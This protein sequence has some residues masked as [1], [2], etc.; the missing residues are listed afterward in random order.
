MAVSLSLIGG[1]GWQFF[2]NSGVPLTGG[3]VYTYA[4]GTTTPAATYTSASGLTAHT[5]PIVLDSAGR[6]PS[7]IWLDNSVSYKFVLKTSTDVLIATYDDVYGAASSADVSGI[8]ANFANTS[9]VSKGDA[10]VGFK[11]STPAGVYSTAVGRTVHDKLQEFVSPLDFGAS[12]EGTLNDSP[13]IQYAVD[14]G[15]GALD[16]TDKV[17]RLGA[18]IL[19]KNGT[20]RV[21][22]F[23][24]SR[25]RT[26]YVPNAVDI[27]QSPQNVN[28]LFFVQ[29][30]NAH[31]CLNNAYFANGGY[32]YTGSIIYCKEGGGADASGQALFSGLFSNL[33]ISPPST[34]G[35]FLI[36]AVQNC[37]F[38]TIT[39]ENMK[40]V[41]NLQG[42][43][44]G[45]VFF[46]NFSLYVCYDSFIYQGTDTY[47]A[48]YFTVNNI[49]A[50]SHLRGRL[51]DV[52]N[53]SNCRISNVMIAPDVS[54][55]GDTGLFKFKDCQNVVVENFQASTYTGSG[56]DV[57][58]AVGIEVD[59]T[60]AKF[61]SGYVYADVG[62]MISGTGAIDIEIENVDFSRCGIGI[63]FNGAA[64]GTIRTRNCKFNNINGTT[65]AMTVAN[66]VTWI[67]EGD[68]FINAGMGGAAGDRYFGGG[69]NGYFCL[70]N[71]RIGKQ[72]SSAAA[73][74]I[75]DQ[76]GS[77]TFKLVNPTFVG[78]PTF[79]VKTGAS[80]LI[81]EQL[82][83]SE[84]PTYGATVGLNTVI[85][86]EFYINVTN[87]TAFTIDNPLF[88]EP[89]MV[90]TVTIK[91]TSGGAV[92]T[93]TWNTKFKLSTWTSPATG[94][95]RSI[96]F[97]YN[98]TNWVEVSRTT[99]DVPN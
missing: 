86:N 30:N 78:I 53:W 81:V 67:S 40:G 48:N 92:G 10:L 31:F 44:N 7:E 65:V 11:Q 49:Q 5:N 74:W 93:V 76:T 96:T 66:T 73:G 60:K 42:V 83:G 50:Y 23:A 33:W 51:F 18:P 1:A 47:G 27:K 2:T 79:G 87:G 12:G 4:A 15:A 84:S 46:N 20:H 41:F 94:Y 82:N 14:S 45:D 64:S 62:L 72:D 8:Y 77:G 38:D 54:N 58:C 69:P 56:L 97:S 55:V 3:L 43:G 17:W 85:A 59:T 68:E 16:M 25:I 70:T 29:D 28:T 26:Q 88:A 37:A 22:L 32:G 95:N 52:Q 21:T 57:K 63:Q 36:G 99:A 89:G 75:F 98:G 61:S 24:N 80:P 9:D 6:P 34:N 35:G 91:N 19:I 71:A 90:I 13:Y 39:C